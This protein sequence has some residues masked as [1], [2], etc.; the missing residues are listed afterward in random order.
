MAQKNVTFCDGCDKP[1]GEGFKVLPNFL[2]KE[3][4]E[5]CFSCA[6]RGLRELYGLTNGQLVAVNENATLPAPPQEEKDEQFKAFEKRK[7]QLE[8]ENDCSIYVVKKDGIGPGQ[9]FEHNKKTVVAL[10]EVPYRPG[11]WFI[12]VPGE[13]S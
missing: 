2:A 5:L 12:K 1:E 7:S 10:E 9:E 4:Q 3:G 13:M 11:A 6:M 8:A